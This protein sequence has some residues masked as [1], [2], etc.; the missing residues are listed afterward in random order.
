MIES[1][2]IDRNNLFKFP[3]TKNDNPGGWIEVTDICNL[4]CP[5]CFRHT[6]T[7]HRPPDELKKEIKQLQKL[8]NCSRISIAGGEPLLYPHIIEI[9][10]FITKNKLKAIILTNGELLTEE[11]VKELQQAGLFQFYFH[12]DSNQNRPGWKG[13]IELEMNELRQHYI[14]LVNKCSKIK[15]GFLTTV[16]P[17]TLH[18]LPDIVKWFH[19]NIQ[20]VIHMAFIAFRGIPIARNYEYLVNGKLVDPEILPNK[21]RDLSEID[22]SINEMYEIIKSYFSEL[23]PCAYLKGTTREDSYKFLIINS[24]SSNKKIFGSIGYKTVS[25]QQSLNR[26]IHARYSDTIPNTGKEIFF[27]SLIDKQVRKAFINY[28]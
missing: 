19:G 1:S 15:C 13:K 3:W 9:V 14:D 12:V 6:I 23:N 26:R 2:N 28:L 10:D 7:G 16:T 25:L 21:C 8:T 11:I 5:G 20:K 27:L 4:R 22:I 17:S 24:I 18:S